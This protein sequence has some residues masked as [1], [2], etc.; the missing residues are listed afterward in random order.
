MW[1]GS[2]ARSGGL[3]DPHAPLPLWEGS[4]EGFVLHGRSRRPHPT[5]KGRGA[6]AIQ[7]SR[8][9]SP[10][11]ITCA[12]ISAAPSKID[13]MRASQSTR[14]IG[15]LHRVAV[16]AMDLQR[17]VG[18]GEGHARG[19]QLRHPRLDIAT[20]PGVLPPRGEIRQLAD[21]H[22]FG[23]HPGELV[24]PTRG[25]ARIDVPNCLPVARVAG[26]ELQ[27]VLRHAQ[28]ARARS[29]CARSRTSPSTA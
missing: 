14:L 4:G 18:I 22:R 26:A 2:C 3:P 11:A 29:G 7:F 19:E 13:R 21:Q 10:R 27:R 25:N 23:R 5:R 12:W 28:R 9:R 20:L 17:A 1:S 8:P 6:S 16:A 24:A 15:V